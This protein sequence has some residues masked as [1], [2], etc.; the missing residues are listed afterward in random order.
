MTPYETAISQ[1][2]TRPTLI[3]GLKFLPSLEP[4][5]SDNRDEPAW[6][7]PYGPEVSDGNLEVVRSVVERMGDKCRAILEIGVHRNEG[8]S[9]TNILMDRRPAGSVYVG[10]DIDDKSYLDDH[11]KKNFTIKSNSHDQKK[12]RSFLESIGVKEI[13]ILMI[14]GWHSVNTCINDWCYTDMLSQHGCVI[15]HDTNAHPGCISL[16]HSVDEN[17]FEKTRFHTEMHDMGISTF[18]HKAKTS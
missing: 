18:W 12:I 17:L 9:M 11:S 16:F 3:Y 6:G 1:I 2:T 13:D 10:V 15:L 4:H 5:V 8:R 14:D 7:W